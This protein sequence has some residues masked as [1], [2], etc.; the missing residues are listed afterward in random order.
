MATSTVTPSVTGS[1][2]NIA[3]SP[4]EELDDEDEDNPVLDPHTSHARASPFYKLVD[5][6]FKK[7]AALSGLS[8]TYN[9]MFQVALQ[10]LQEPGDVT[11]KKPVFV[12]VSGI[13]NMLS[14]VGRQFTLFPLME[15]QS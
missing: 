7:P 5:F 11:R 6:I 2:Q 12:L 15:E 4:D 13:I 1:I 3:R 8:S 9:E 10:L 14:P